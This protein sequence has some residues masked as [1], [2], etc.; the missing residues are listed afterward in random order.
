LIDVVRVRPTGSAEEEKMS[1]H[2]VGVLV[3]G[4]GVLAACGEGP[5]DT[6][7]GVRYFPLTV[8][9]TWTYA[10][11]QAVFGE[12]FQWRVTERHGDTVTVVRPTGASHSG[13]VTLLDR[14]IE[15]DVLLDGEGA[16]PFY[17][18]ATGSSWLH[19]DMWECDDGSRWV[20]AKEENPITTPAGTFVGTLRIERLSTATCADAGTMIEWWAR[21]VGLV[22]WEELNFYA[23]GPLTYNLV[24]YSVN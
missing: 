2:G 7:A 14:R 3:I 22:R 17:R 1:I 8:G 20:V 4:L 21:D 16:V 6:N 5:T 11:E 12:P 23:G 18:F 9:S 19:R 13:S 15:L 10:P 24:S